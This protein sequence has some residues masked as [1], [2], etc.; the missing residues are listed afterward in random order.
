[1]TAMRLL[2]LSRFI[3]TN[4]VMLSGKKAIPGTEVPSTN[5]LHVTGMITHP[6]SLKLVSAVGANNKHR[7]CRQPEPSLTLR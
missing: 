7:F 3:F 6:C 5:T 1:M 4:F 2:G